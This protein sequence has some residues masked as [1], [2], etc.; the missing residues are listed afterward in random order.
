MAVSKVILNGT[1]LI[2]TT[3]KTVTAGSMLN[4]VTALKNDGTTATGSIAS[5]SSTDLTASGATV[6]APAGYYS[7]SASKSVASGTAGTPTASKGTVSNHSISVTPSVTNTAGYISGGTK[8]GTAV[9]VSASELVSGTKSISGAGETDVTNYEK[10]SVSAGSATT[11]TTTITANPTISVSSAGLITASVSESQNVTPSVSA[12]YVSSGT[13][14]TV[15]VSGSKTQ[16]LTAKAAT[17]YYP[18]TTDQTITS[19]QYLTGTQTIKAVTTTN[20]T[21]EN[22]ADGVTVEVGDTS[23]SD[24]ILSITGT[25]QGGTTPTGVKY[26]YT[27]IDGDGAWDVS[28]YQYCSVNYAAVPDEKWRYWIKV[29]SDDLTFTLNNSTAAAALYSSNGLIDWGDGSEYT[30]WDYEHLTNTHTYSAPG[31][32]V[33]ETWRTGGADYFNM[34]APTDKSKI[35]AVD[36]FMKGYPGNTVMF[37]SMENL[38]A[39]RYSGNQTKVG[40]MRDNSKLATLVFPMSTTTITD[41]YRNIAL[42]SLVIPASVVTIDNNAFLNNTGMKE[43]HVLPTIP[44]TIGAYTFKGIPSDCIIYVPYSADHSILEAYKAA[45]NWSTYASKMQEEPS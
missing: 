17:T 22:I 3:D 43:Y 42:T 19:G 13:A 6:T 21:A 41:C 27:D 33:V 7:S 20:L 29:D 34:A 35:I 39:V 2:D 44:P 9:T 45:T 26:I 28:G 31:L 5:K 18:S 14:G 40:N 24:R 25:H 16:Q 10:A 30:E 32:Y 15:S 37:A 12:G 8:S 36:F 4:G 23:D 1:T 38:E 11:P